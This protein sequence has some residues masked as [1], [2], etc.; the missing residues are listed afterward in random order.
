MPSTIIRII[1]SL[2][3]LSIVSCQSGINQNS[4]VDLV[5][6][7]TINSSFVK[8]TSDFKTEQ[9]TYSR[10]RTAYDE[11]RDYIEAFLKENGYDGFDNELFIR[12]FKEDEE[13]EVWLRPV[14]TTA[15]EK[16][17]K[18]LVTYDIC[19][20]SGTLGP[21]RLQGDEQIPEGFYHIDRFNPSGNFYLSLGLNYPNASDKILGEQG[22][23]GGDIFIHGSCVTIGCVPITD[24]L[25]K[26]LYVL[27]IEAR[28]TGQSKIPVHIFPTRLTEANLT[29][30]AAKN[31]SDALLNFW[32]NLKPGYDYFEKNHVL[33][34]IGVD[35]NGAYYLKDIGY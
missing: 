20:L 2:F 30:L 1:T 23:L 16:E 29:T 27:A 31:Y 14:A 25:I 6:A 12:I 15:S 18:L 24:A 10:V 22:N 21:K 19:R 11:K 9:L 4:I 28:T 32:R 13:V 7:D 33:P 3:I 5:G 34:D 26:E 35:N 8:T 17:F